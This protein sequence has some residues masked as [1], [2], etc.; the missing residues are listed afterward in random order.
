VPTQTRAEWLATLQRTISMQPEHI[1]AYCLTYEE[2]TQFFARFRQGELRQDIE[3]DAD[4]FELT[5]DTLGAAG[6]AQYEI[7][8]YARPG[9]ECQHNL[10]YWLGRD[11]LGLGPSAFSTGRNRRWQNAADTTAYGDRIH[12]GTFAE[13]FTE[14]LSSDVRRSEAIAFSLRT[15]RGVPRE[16]A[17]HWESEWQNLAAEGLVY[18]ENDRWLLTP[19][20][21]LV[22]DEIA[23]AFV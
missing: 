21:K 18:P 19:R 13:S 12:A 6:Y 22:A 11:Y 17:A 5:M 8:N 14:E 20:G 23:A 4:F 16:L 15:D 1:S 7:S 10:A 3:V 9:R 2:D